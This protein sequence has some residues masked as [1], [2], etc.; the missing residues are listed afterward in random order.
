VSAGTH[1]LSYI[2]PTTTPVSPIPSPSQVSN[3]P[4]HTLP[5]MICSP[6]V[7]P[8]SQV[9]HEI[10]A[11]PST[12]VCMHIPAKAKQLCSLA[13]P[14]PI[15]KP[16]KRAKT[17]TPVGM[18]KQA[19]WK[20]KVLE[21]INN[22]TWVQ[23]IQKWETY[24]SKLVALDSQFEV[25]DEPRH[26][27]Y[28]RHSCC[29]SWIL[30]A[31]P[32]DIGHFQAHVTSCSYSTAS[33]GMRTLH[34]YGVM[35]MNTQSPSLS[36]A[37]I[38]SPP[39]HTDLPCLGITEKDDIR[40]A[41]YIKCTPVNSAGGGT[42][43]DIAE[44][45]FSSDFKDL[46]QK[47]KEI[48]RQKQVQSHAWSNDPIRKS[49]HAIRKNACEGKAH[50]AEDGSLMPCNKCLALLTLRAFRNAISR[51]CRENGNQRY[52]PHIFQSPDIGRICSLGLYELLD[53]VCTT[54]I[55]TQC[56][57]QLIP[58]FQTCSHGETLM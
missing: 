22:G 41:Q 28:V 48:V 16:L 44:S 43:Q 15:D 24:K 35:N 49:V 13:F 27:R 31:L 18:S 53:G 2:L 17:S 38:S 54:S 20:W 34:S 36:V 14:S 9:T 50:L 45:L 12:D 47:D 26:A 4:F 42:I 1:D 55:L 37:S 3:D 57:T 46:S 30:M 52:T 58:P 25:S 19:V 32:Y 10:Q 23:D 51:K 6:P 29:G 56:S 21:Q 40:I 7:P 11:S 5:T 33:G 39:P 8:P